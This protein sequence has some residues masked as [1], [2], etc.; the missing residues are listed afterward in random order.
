MDKRCESFYITPPDI[1]DT[2]TCKICIVYIC[3]LDALPNNSSYIR[4]Y[5]VKNPENKLFKI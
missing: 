5:S 4:L 2:E 1:Y 3:V